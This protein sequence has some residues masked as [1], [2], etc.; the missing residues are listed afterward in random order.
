MRLGPSTKSRFPTIWPNR[1]KSAVK[2]QLLLTEGFFNTTSRRRTRYTRDDSSFG[3]Q[4]N[5]LRLLRFPEAEAIN[6]D[7]ATW[8]FL[9]NEIPAFAVVE[10]S[11]RLVVN[12]RFVPVIGKGLQAQPQHHTGGKFLSEANPN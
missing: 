11:C 5:G 7:P 1:D 12:D 9:E 6:D 8:S 10:A 2:N 3:Q 4:R